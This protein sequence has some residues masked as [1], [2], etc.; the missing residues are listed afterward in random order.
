MK[1]SV[2]ILFKGLDIIAASCRF[3]SI[4]NYLICEMDFHVV[5]NS[6]VSRE[7]TRPNEQLKLAKQVNVLVDEGGIYLAKQPI[8]PCNRLA[9]VASVISRQLSVYFLSFSLPLL[10]YSPPKS[11]YTKRQG[12]FSGVA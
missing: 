12:N 5:Q 10:A 8:S 11:L 4:V 3:A 6:F 2:A 1:Q 9:H 7:A